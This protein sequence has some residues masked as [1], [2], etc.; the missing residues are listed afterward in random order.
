MALP[1]GLTQE[2]ADELFRLPMEQFWRYLHRV[3]DRMALEVDPDALVLEVGTRIFRG[4]VTPRRIA[5]RYFIALDRDESRPGLTV[6]VLERPVYADV[7][8]STCLLHHTPEADVPRALKNL[9]AP[10]LMFSGPTADTHAPYGDHQWHLE[11]AKLQGWLGDLGYSMTFE[12]FGMTEPYCEAV[13][14]A[15]RK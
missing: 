13:V 1:A 7:I 10:L 2:V 14:I 9:R 4:I 8:L 6:D 12:R 15:R 5:C 11:P 3:Y